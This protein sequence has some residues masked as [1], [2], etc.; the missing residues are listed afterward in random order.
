[1][2]F[3]PEMN[4]EVVISPAGTRQKQREEPALDFASLPKPMRLILKEVVVKGAASPML[5]KAIQSTLDLAK[6]R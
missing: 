2:R 4:D 1:M 6:G 3:P 5:L